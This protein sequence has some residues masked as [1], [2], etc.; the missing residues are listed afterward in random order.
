MAPLG[1]APG[2]D[3]KEFGSNLGLTHICCVTLGSYTASLSL[4]LF[5]CNSVVIRPPYPWATLKVK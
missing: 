4:S 5:I 1:R 2:L 3:S